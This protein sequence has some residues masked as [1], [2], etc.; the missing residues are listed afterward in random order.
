MMNEQKYH[1]YLLVCWGQSKRLCQVFFLEYPKYSSVTKTLFDLWLPSFS[2]LIH[3]SRVNFAS[4]LSVCDNDIVRRVLWVTVCLCLC[5]CVYMYDGPQLSEITQM[6]EMNEGM[7]EWNFANLC[8]TCV[9][10]I[11]CQCVAAAIS[12]FVTS[13][14]STSAAQ[15]HQQRR[16]KAAKLD[17]TE[18]QEDETASGPGRDRWERLSE[19]GEV[20]RWHGHR[21]VVQRQQWSAHRPL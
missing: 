7:N 18:I 16:Q 8:V 21:V 14:T 9:L 1:H 4:R 3:N 10:T 11:C 13:A 20:S 19:R 15:C 2:T 6:N 17:K 12:G 5:L